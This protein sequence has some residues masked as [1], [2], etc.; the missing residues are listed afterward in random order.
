MTMLQKLTHGD[1]VELRMNNPPF[2]A[3]NPALVNELL[4]ALQATQ[5]SDARAIVLSGTPAVFS[6]GVDAAEVMALNRSQTQQ[7][8]VQFHN[9][10]V[11]LGRS[12]IP[13]IAAITGHAPAGG[14]ILALFCD[15]RVMAQGPFQIG[16]HQVRMG[17]IVPTAIRHLLAR[18]IGH[19]LAERLLVE[20][21]MLAPEEALRIGLV[22]EVAAPEAV[23]RHALHH[24]M[25]M[26]AL[27]ASAMNEMRDS[28]H[29]EVHRELG[30]RDAIIDELLENWFSE[31]AQ[32][33]MRANFSRIQRA[34]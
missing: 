9:L 7:F 16:L 25:R 10:C 18:L 21:K 5:K 2:N 4:Q 17:I 33:S 24:C 12:P 28:F 30:D 20:G 19:R 29:E 27:P 34:S 14:T 1:V 23:L 15:Y 26:L 6:V 32:A 11:A 31:E 8:F 13:V 3:L 22:D